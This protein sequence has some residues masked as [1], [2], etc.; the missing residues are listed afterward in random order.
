MQ[1]A[2]SKIMLV[3]WLV[4][5][6]FLMTC[7][8]PPP[9]FMSCSGVMITPWYSRFAMAWDWQ[10][11]CE[12]CIERQYKHTWKFSWVAVSAQIKIALY[13]VF[14]KACTF[15]IPRRFN[16]ITMIRR[17]FLGQ[18]CRGIQNVRVF[19]M[20][21]PTI[22]TTSLSLFKIASVTLICHKHRRKPKAFS[23]ESQISEYEGRFTGE[24]LAVEASPETS[25]EQVATLS[26]EGRGGHVD[27]IV[28][29]SIER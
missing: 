15:C 1:W 23:M 14:F 28:H 2:L 21:V 7:L 8:K 24:C 22:D 6:T 19:P 4:K 29:G 20:P 16:G 3:M 13:P 17:L 11:I 25:T 27:A 10:E 9:G 18:K 12:H 26:P 5:C